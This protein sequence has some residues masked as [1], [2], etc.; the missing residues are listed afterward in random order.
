[1]TLTI[2]V[3]VNALLMAGIV[4]ALSYVMHLPFGFDRRR[5]LGTA[6]YLPRDGNRDELD[7]AA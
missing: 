2:A 6:V 7:R 1:M 5:T 3:I 4:A